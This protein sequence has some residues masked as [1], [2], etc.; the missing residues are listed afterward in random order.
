MSDFHNCMNKAWPIVLELL[1]KHALI[2]VTLDAVEAVILSD[3]N[4]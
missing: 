3:R 2:N 1:E 4:Y